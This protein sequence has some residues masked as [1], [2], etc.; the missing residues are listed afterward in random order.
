[1][2]MKIY[3]I[4][5]KKLQSFNMPFVAENEVVATRQF[6]I[7]AKDPAA[8]LSHYADDFD[9]YELG[10]FEPTTGK[11]TAVEPKFLIGACSFQK[12]VERGN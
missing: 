1:M 6:G 8:Q 5:D 2:A 10:E 4:R 3:S 11:L 7:L 9:L 12:M